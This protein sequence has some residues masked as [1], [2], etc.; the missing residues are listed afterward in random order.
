M[1]L[2]KA[3]L[4]VRHPPALLLWDRSGTVWRNILKALPGAEPVEAQPNVTRFRLPPH[5]DLGVELE[6]FRLISA[7]PERKLTEFKRRCEVFSRTVM[8]TLEISQLLRLGLRV[9]YSIPAK[10]A[11]AAADLVLSGGMLRTPPSLEQ[12][13]PFSG[14]VS[15]PEVAFRWEGKAIGV[16]YRLRAEMRNYELSIPPEFPPEIDAKSIKRSLYYAT[17]DLDYYTT[18][19]ISRDQLVL[20]EWMESG[21]RVLKREADRMLGGSVD[22]E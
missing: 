10:T 22:A 2:E 16:S 5:D 7:N 11:E 15:L 13:P 17:L 18:V 9:I 1:K 19:N 6:V 3:V 4:E 20:A 8:D 14:R 12:R 21:F